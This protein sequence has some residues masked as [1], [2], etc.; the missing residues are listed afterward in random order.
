MATGYM[1]SGFSEASVAALRSRTWACSRRAGRQLLGGYLL[2]PANHQF[3]PG[4]LSAQSRQLRPCPAKST[5]KTCWSTVLL[6]AFNNHV[7]LD[8]CN[9]FNAA[10]NSNRFVNF[11]AGSDKSSQLN[12]AFVGFNI[13]FGRL[14]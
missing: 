6:L 1:D 7:I 12:N 13:D 3:L 11:G 8:R 5:H 2:V 10:G 14:E 4:L 9:P